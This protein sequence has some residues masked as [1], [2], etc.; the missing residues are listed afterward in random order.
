MACRYPTN[1]ICFA[2]FTVCVSSNGV[3]F[4]FGYNMEGALGHVDVISLPKEI[5]SLFDI[6]AV[7]CGSEH[8]VFL[9]FY[10]TVFQ[11]VIYILL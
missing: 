2:G 8:S 6:K 7:S 4:S 11:K 1:I 9:D 5:C 3:V 10:G